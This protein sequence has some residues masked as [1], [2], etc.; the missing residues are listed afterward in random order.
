[1]ARI[2]HLWLG[3]VFGLLA[4]TNPAYAQEGWYPVGAPNITNIS[5]QTVGGITYFTH[6]SRVEECCRRVNPG[7]V[8]Q[9]GTNLVQ[10]INQEAWGGICF[11]TFCEPRAETHVSVL[12]ALPAGDYLLQLSAVDPF[13][14]TYPLPWPFRFIQFNVPPADPPTMQVWTVG[15]QLHISVLGIA[16]VSYRIE[17]SNDF[18]N[19]VG[20]FSRKGAPFE[21]NQ[22][23]STGHQMRFY[24][25][26]I[27]GY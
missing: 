3:I 2:K 18:E 21:W 20:V 26:K 10:I 22:P 16:E 9:Q 14:P 4:L 19:W 25:L 6:I 15:N 23:I 7:P 5:F 24:R 12:G 17:A 1:M 27:E 8:T 11:F 13:S